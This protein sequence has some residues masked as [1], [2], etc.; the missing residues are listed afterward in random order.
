MRPVKIHLPGTKH[1]ASFAW[2]LGTTTGGSLLPGESAYPSL[3]TSH[4]FSSLRDIVI[5][6]IVLD[7]AVLG[8]VVLGEVVIRVMRIASMGNRCLP[9]SGSFDAATHMRMRMVNI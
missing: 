7:D 6:D 4:H 8:D 2:R 5:G 9:S 3:V 1:A